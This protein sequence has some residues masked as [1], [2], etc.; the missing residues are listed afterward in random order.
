ML[1]LRGEQA[2]RAAVDRLTERGHRPVAPANPYWA[3]GGAILFE[4]PDGWLVVLTP[5]VFGEQPSAG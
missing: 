3:R 4:D 5:W 2:Q 1:Y